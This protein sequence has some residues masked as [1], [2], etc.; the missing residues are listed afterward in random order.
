MIV[1]E[2]RQDIKKQVADWKKQGLSIGLVPT[3]GYLHEGHE[4]LIIRARKENDRV[5]V[6]DF[7]NPLQFGPTEDLATYPR[8]FERDSAICERLGADLIFHPSVEDMYDNDHYTGI[9]VD[10]LTAGLCGASR[11]GHFDGVCAV[12]NKL[13]N[14]SGCDRAYFGQKDAQQLAVVRRMARDLDMPLEI[15][16]CPIVREEDGL[17]KSS[18]NINL[19][20]EERKDAPSIQKALQYGKSLIEGGEK[21]VSKITKEVTERIDKIPGANIDYVEIVSW[22]NLAEIEEICGPV[23]MACAVR[24]GK[25][26][27]IDNIIVE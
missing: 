26:R 1:C 11:P 16:G 19:T 2:K 7:V 18:R 4:S 5:I 21:S 3:M 13:F 27:L 9:H 15:I 12:V 23:L 20:S 6:S 10:T 22:D 17:A 24:L 14:L 8:D 25:V